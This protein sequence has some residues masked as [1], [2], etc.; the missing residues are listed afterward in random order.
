M[1]KVQIRA[2]GTK[3]LKMRK[4]KEFLNRLLV[5]EIIRQKSLR[6]VLVIFIHTLNYT[7]QKQKG[8]SRDVGE[9]QMAVFLETV[10]ILHPIISPM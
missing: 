3:K 1:C 9:A 8:T 2:K 10:H 6:R 7:P 5:N 4:Y